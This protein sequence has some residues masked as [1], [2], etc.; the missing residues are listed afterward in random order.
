MI[1][2][3]CSDA[4]LIEDILL[5]FL[6]SHFCFLGASLLLVFVLRAFGDLDDDG[7]SGGELIDGR[8]R[9]VVPGMHARD[10]SPIA[11]GIPPRR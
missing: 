9:H 11:A 7:K 1:D 10:F 8:Q 5:L 3:I 4:L 2:C 6:Y